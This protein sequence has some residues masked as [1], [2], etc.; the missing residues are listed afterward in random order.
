M[1]CAVQCSMFFVKTYQIF[2]F[3]SYYQVTRGN[4]LIGLDI[5]VRLNFIAQVLFIADFLVFYK[6]K[7]FQACLFNELHCS[8]SELFLFS[9]MD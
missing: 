1:C 2:Y 6:V 7:L 3:E 9:I 4:I 8:H 5:S